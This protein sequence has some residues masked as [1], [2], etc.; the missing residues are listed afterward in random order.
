[1]QTEKSLKKKIDCH[2]QDSNEGSSLEAGDVPITELWCKFCNNN[3]ASHGLQSS[4]MCG[5]LV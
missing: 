3:I 4:Y 1:M 5:L 2:H